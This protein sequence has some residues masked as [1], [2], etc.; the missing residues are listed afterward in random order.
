[1]PLSPRKLSWDPAQPKALFW[2]VQQCVDKGF[3][4]TSSHMQPRA[5]HISQ[6]VPSMAISFS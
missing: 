3:Q 6:W 1:M 5:R 2:V 4:R